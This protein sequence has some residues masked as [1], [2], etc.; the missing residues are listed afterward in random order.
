MLTRNSIR[1][2][3][4]KI[5][6]EY[7]SPPT[8]A[9]VKCL[10]DEAC[11]FSIWNLQRTICQINLWSS[12]DIVTSNGEKCLNYWESLSHRNHSLKKREKKTRNIII[13]IS[14]RYS[15]V[16]SAHLLAL[17]YPIHH[18]LQMIRKQGATPPFFP[19][20]ANC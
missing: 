14:P 17:H 20:C 19:A 5:T 6:I 15:G 7:L 2:L 18:A 10:K 16:C 13:L 11:E 4:M 1:K 8:F 3:E 9:Y 12:Q